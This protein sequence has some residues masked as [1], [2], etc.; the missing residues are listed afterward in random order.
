MSDQNDSGTRKPDY[1]NSLYFKNEQGK[2]RRVDLP[3]SWVNDKGRIVTET[4]V[5][6]LVQTPREMLEQ[7]RSENQE[8]SQTQNQEPEYAPKP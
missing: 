8:Q 2:N 6:R 7:M 3:P 1:I 5:G 4:P